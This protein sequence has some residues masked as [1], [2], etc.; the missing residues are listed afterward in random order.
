MSDC[1][2]IQEAQSEMKTH[3]HNLTKKSNIIWYIL[4]LIVHVY[5]QVPACI[6]SFLQLFMFFSQKIIKKFPC[7][8]FFFYDFKATAYA[9]WKG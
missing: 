1:W 6:H 3:I 8:Q 7:F 2:K 5:T 4:L 9:T